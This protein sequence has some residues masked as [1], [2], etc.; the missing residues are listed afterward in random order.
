MNVSQVKKCTSYVV[1]ITAAFLLMNPVQAQQL[2][3]KTAHSAAA[4][5]TGQKA[6][7]FLDKELREKTKGKIGLEIY[8]NSQLGGERELIEAIQLGNVDLIFT[9]SAPLGSFNKQFF[10]LDLPFAFKDRPTVYKV[11]DGEIGEGLLKSLDQ[12][13]IKGLGYWENSFRQ[14]SN[15][16]R[17]VK[18]AADLASMKMRTMENEVHIAA[19]KAVGANPAPLAFSE[20]FTALQQGT[21]DASEMPINLFYDMKYFE[22]QKFIS[23]TNHLY[24]PYVLQMNPDVYNR[25]SDEEKKIFMEAFAKAKVYQRDLAAK[26]DDAAEAAM[27]MVKFTTL[28]PDELK[29]FSSKMG[30]VIEMVKKQVSHAERKIR[31]GFFHRASGLFGKSGRDHPSQHSHGHLSDLVQHVGDENVRRW[32]HSRYLH[33][34]CP[35]FIRLLQIQTRR[36]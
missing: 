29:T 35:D 11:L 30:P 27:P 3:L 16:K 19:F 33:R 25:F 8:P 24:S 26:A 28:T 10:A 23:K 9:S 32:S 1:G 15:S 7:E 22:V 6:F 17:E 20:L 21:F 5:N 2:I 12:V 18:T 36:S 14:L 4:T 13:G 34:H 31:S